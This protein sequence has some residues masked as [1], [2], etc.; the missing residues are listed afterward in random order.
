MSGNTTRFQTMKYQAEI[1]DRMQLLYEE[2]GFNDHMVHCEIRMDSRLD[3]SLLRKATAL[4]LESIP[5][6]ATAFRRG[7]RG[8]HWGSIAGTELERA[9]SAVEDEAGFEAE[10]TYCIPEAEGPQLRVGFL[11]GERSAVAITVNHMVADGAGLKD[12]AYFL[13]ET[14]SRLRED[15]DYRPPLV[16]GFRG[17]ADVMRAAGPIAAFRALFGRGGASNRSGDIAFPLASA[18]EERPFIAT[19]TLD[20]AKVARLKA[21]CKE[22]GATL[23]DA[24]IAAFYRVLVGR[25]GDAG[26][27]RLEVPV[28][29]DMRRY[30]GSR[31]FKSLRNLSSTVVTR[32][33]IG[34]GESFEE[35]L[36]KA[37]AFMDRLKGE[38][39]GLGAF[40]KMSILSALPPPAADRLMRR[41]FRHPLVC[42]TNLG[43]LDSSRLHLAGT[44]VV[45]AYA[46]GSIKR[47]PHFQLALSGFEGTI[48]L[49]SNLRGTAEDRRIIDA[50]LAEVEEEM[51]TDRSR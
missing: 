4:C 50:F 34:E 18:G 9:F 11:R 8:P 41:G 39:I 16:D 13:C 51:A 24:A 47:K 14:Y 17:L 29:V 38:D 15:P 48:T 21:F 19:R 46:C 26:G 42:M 40:A 44:R 3:E 28:M 35:S 32:L 37:K 2:G 27:K 45:S 12:C 1:F 6:L 36:A 30:L 20:R 25:L 43:E 49:S 10:R 22:R 7:P 33:G 5:I 31:D 23:N